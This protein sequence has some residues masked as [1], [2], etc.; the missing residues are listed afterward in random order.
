MWI[1]NTIHLESIEMLDQ[2]TLVSGCLDR[3]I[4]QITSNQVGKRHSMFSFLSSDLDR[5]RALRTV[6]KYWIDSQKNF[7]E[8][9]DGIFHLIHEQMNEH[10]L[11]Y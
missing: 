5:L 7:D 4:L 11:D 2:F 6:Q 10:V 1:S 9:F 3:N 8:I